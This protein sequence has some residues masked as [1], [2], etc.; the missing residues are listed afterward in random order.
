MSGSSAWPGGPRL[1]LALFLEQSLANFRRTGRIVDGDQIAVLGEAD[2]V[3]LAAAEREILLGRRED[4]AL[5]AQLE[6]LH[7]L[8]Q[9]LQLGLG[10]R[11]AVGRGHVDDAD[12]T[13]ALD[14]G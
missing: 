3:L 9:R 2:Q 14:V 13:D 5:R 7:L 10:Q 8:G 1:L 11:P 12:M 6:A 4:R